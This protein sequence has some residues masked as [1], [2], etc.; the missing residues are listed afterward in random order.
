MTL[1]KYISNLTEF[2]KEDPTRAALEVITAID[3]E[4]NGYNPVQ[5][6]PSI[7]VYD[8]SEFSDKACMEENYEDD[9]DSYDE[10]YLT[11]FNAVLIN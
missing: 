4:G 11:S 7:G 5:Y 10:D 2:V 8:D 1:E 3:D 9:P 6:G